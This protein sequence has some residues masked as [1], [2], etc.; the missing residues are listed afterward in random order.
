MRRFF[1]ILILA[2]SLPAVAQAQVV[3]SFPTPLT[4]A[5]GGTGST[6]GATV[7]QG[8][9][10]LPGTCSVR[11]VYVDTDQPTGAGLYVCTATNTWTNVTT[12]ATTAP[13]G[14]GTELQYRNSGAFGAVAGTDVG[15]TN[16]RVRVQAQAATEVPITIK[17]AAAQTA[18]LHNWKDNS[19]TVLASVSADGTPHF[20]GTGGATTQRLG[21]GSSA[22]YTDAVSIG[23]N[24]SAT[25]ADSTA[26]GYDADCTHNYSV[27]IGSS[28]DSTAASQ[29]VIGGPG[30]PV[31]DVYIGFGGVKY[32][33]A[34]STYPLNHY[35]TGGSGSNITGSDAFWNGGKSTGDTG[36]GSVG[37]KTSYPGA[38]GSSENA[39]THR[40][41]APSKWTTLT[42]SSA[43]AIATLTYNASTAV[44]AELLVTVEANDGTDYQSMTYRVAVNSA[45]KATGNT[46]TTEAVI[47]T[48]P[49]AAET[50][51]ASTLTC[52]FDDTEGASAA[53]LNA[54]CVSSLTQ[55]TLRATWQAQA[56]GP[57]TLTQN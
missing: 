31:T 54:N 30:G 29:V 43:T 10:T 23:V 12:G 35:P 33:S 38:S 24:S 52:T 44:G 8:S 17:G 51:G 5:L 15:G 11:D 1:A 46:V 42:E 14:S 4:T 2:F 57:V 9:T 22:T 28:A 41:I 13:A 6:T 56:N 48:P 49:T 18:N 45:R 47:G 40:Y 27:C 3:G 55:T 25:A 32:S 26:I 37:M 50:S 36:G 19:D 39:G 21:A 7:I 53:V 20:P 16:M 34:H